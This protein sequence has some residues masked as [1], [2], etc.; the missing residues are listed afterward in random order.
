MINMH[1][2]NDNMHRNRIF[3]VLIG[4]NNYVITIVSCMSS[5]G[6]SQRW[7]SNTSGEVVKGMMF[8]FCN[9]NRI[10]KVITGQSF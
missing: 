4:I 7:M 6:K 1:S 2:K 10:V 3:Y 9:G 8:V 5:H